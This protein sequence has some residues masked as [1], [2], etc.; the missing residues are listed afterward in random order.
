M[1]PAEIRSAGQELAKRTR[2]RQGLPRTIRERATVGRVAALLNGR[3]E[4]V[5]KGPA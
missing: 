5:E 2:A 3:R 4:R 1:T